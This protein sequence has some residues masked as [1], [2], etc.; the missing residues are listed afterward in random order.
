MSN[1]P[2]SPYNRYNY[3]SPFSVTNP[4]SPH[5]NP[6]VVPP[7][8]VLYAVLFVPCL[9]IILG[10][11]FGGGIVDFVDKYTGFMSWHIPKGV[12]AGAAVLTGVSYLIYMIYGWV[13]NG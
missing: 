5:Y 10:Y 6:G 11:A 3:D 12:Q 8:V 9:I 13:K 7:Q 1:N 4:D 2:R